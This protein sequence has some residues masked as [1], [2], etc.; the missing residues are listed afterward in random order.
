MSNW[1]L[2][3]KHTQSINY[4]EDGCLLGCFHRQ[5]D[6]RLIALMM[7]AAGTSGTLVNVYQ[8]TRRYNP[9]DSLIHN[10]RPEN[11]KS[12]SVTIC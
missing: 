4:L 5:G 1:C 8:T 9:E 3:V 7:E 10:H 11:L 6:D 12:Y 2:P